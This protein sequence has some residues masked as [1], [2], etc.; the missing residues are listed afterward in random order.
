MTFKTKKQILSGWLSTVK[1]R[2]KK[3]SVVKRKGKLDQFVLRLLWEQRDELPSVMVKHY[4]TFQ[5]D[6]AFM[7]EG[8]WADC[9]HTGFS[10][11]LWPTVAD[12]PLGF[13]VCFSL[14]SCTLSC[15]SSAHPS[16]MRAL[17][18]SLFPTTAA[19]CNDVCSPCQR[20][21]KNTQH[22]LTTHDKSRQQD[23]G[24]IHR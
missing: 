5:C 9:R 22:W 21:E 2:E 8:G 6:Q 12:L 20:R 17:M 23:K 3:S 14:V 4:R 16:W 11:I 7:E 1:P 13:C 18:T 24:T 10:M 19:R 15:L